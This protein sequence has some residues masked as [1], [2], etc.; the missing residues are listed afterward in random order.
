VTNVTTGERSAMS[1][2]V[3]TIDISRRPEDVFAYVADLARFP[4]WQ[5]DVVSVRGEGDT[6]VGSKAVVTRR[7]GPRK[8]P[9]TE[10]VVELNPPRSWTVRA[11]SGPLVGIAQGTIEPLDFG[12]RSRV[13]IAFDFEAHGIGKLLVAFLIR[14]QV[15]RR[16][17]RNEQKLK[18]VLEGVTE[19]IS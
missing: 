14:P 7:V 11:A 8:L 12:R 1:A 13:T 4:E 10:E 3:A 5:D 19:G 6:P 2:I 18:R 17:P 9:M 15:S 16:L